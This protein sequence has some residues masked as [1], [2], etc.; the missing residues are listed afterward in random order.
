MAQVRVVWGENKNPKK[1]AGLKPKEGKIIWL[2]QSGGSV[3]QG[4]YLL[5]W[6]F[7]GEVGETIS[8][9]IEQDVGG[10]WK[11]RAET[12]PHKI[13]QGHNRVDSIDARPPGYIDI[14]VTVT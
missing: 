9:K 5:V 12:G 3:P 7:L 11:E 10:S 2:S 4:V 1:R 8:L 14:F 6:M 13:S